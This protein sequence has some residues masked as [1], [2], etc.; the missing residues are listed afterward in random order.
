M[1]AVM[2]P[3]ASDKASEQAF[4]E[5]QKL[6]PDKRGVT[7]EVLFYRQLQQVTARIHETENIEQIMLEIGRASCRERV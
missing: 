5:S 2:R 3:S 1:S 4:F 6:P 7:F